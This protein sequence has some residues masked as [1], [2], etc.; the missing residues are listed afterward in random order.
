VIPAIKTSIGTIDVPV[1]LCQKCS[2][3]SCGSHGER[4]GAPAFLC[5]L[6]DTNLQASSAGWATW[7]S[8]PV[9]AERAADRLAA[10]RETVV[11]HLP[12]LAP[13]R[14]TWHMHSPHCSR[15]LTATQA[16]S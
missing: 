16:R 4:T 13:R 15:K 3:L 14:Q 9:A 8:C 10:R 1:G 2:S 12:E 5:I 11:A 6:C 7:L